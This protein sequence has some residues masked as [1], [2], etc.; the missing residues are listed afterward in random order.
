M[1][2]EVAPGQARFAGFQIEV[3][4]LADAREHLACR[5]IPFREGRADDRRPT[6]QIG[7]GT[8]FATAIEFV[9][10]QR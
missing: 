7:S 8:A 5:H 9:A 3:E 4:N 6:L 1:D 10:A 2:A